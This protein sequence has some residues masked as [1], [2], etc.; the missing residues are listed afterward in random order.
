MKPRK[1]STLGETAGA[2]F[3][4]IQRL[5]HRDADSRKTTLKTIRPLRSRVR[6]WIAAAFG[7]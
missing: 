6:H 3:K 2:Q 7:I 5:E 1:A 4:L